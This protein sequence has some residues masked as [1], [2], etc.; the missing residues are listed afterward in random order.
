M[1]N[2]GSL[3]QSAENL[4]AVIKAYDVRGVYPEQ[5]DENLA[6]AVGG[7]FVQVIALRCAM[8]DREPLPWVT[9]CGHQGQT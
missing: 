2:L 7:A 9:T 5:L 6:R 3:T 4:D 1:S 8:V